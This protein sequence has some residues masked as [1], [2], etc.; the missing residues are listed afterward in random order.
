MKIPIASD[1]AGFRLKKIIID[2]FKDIS[3]DDCG[4]NSEES[5]DYPD[6]ISR[7]AEQVENGDVE[8]GIVIC[9]SGIGAS[10]VANKYKNVRASLCFN[11]YM[12]EMTRRHNDSNILALG[13]RIIGDDLALAIVDR[14]LKTSFDGGRHQKRIDKISCIEG[15]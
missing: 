11:E 3:F 4:T 13:A 5:V 6:Y 2:N 10:I 8:K 9:G 15:G 12:A 1:H 7:V 14:W